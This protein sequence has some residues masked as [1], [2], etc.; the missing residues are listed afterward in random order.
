MRGGLA[1]MSS[2]GVTDTQSHVGRRIAGVCLIAVGA[3]VAAVCFLTIVIVC[4]AAVMTGLDN[5]G[6]GTWALV[7]I[8]MAFMFA[9]FGVPATIGVVMVVFGWRLFRRPR[10]IALPEN[11]F[12]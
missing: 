9:I 1:V 10:P 4:G 7:L 6:Q 11:T 3:L 2:S 8:T 5:H 12:V